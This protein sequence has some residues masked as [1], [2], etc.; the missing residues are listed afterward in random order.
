MAKYL[1]EAQIEG[2]NN[3]KSNKENKQIAMK[4]YNEIG[5]IDSHFYFEAKRD[6]KKERR[7]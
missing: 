2:I 3:E 7:R 5:K 6:K 1:S 4:L